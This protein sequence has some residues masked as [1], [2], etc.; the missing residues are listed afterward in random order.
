MVGTL[1][2]MSPEQ[3]E[4]SALGVDTRS[5]IYSLG[6]LLYE[7]LTGT[8][9]L[10]RKRV[11]EAAYAEILRMIREEEPPKPSTRLSDS[12]EALPS[13]SDQPR[14]SEPAKLIEADAR[15]AGLDR[16]EDAGEGPQPPLRIRCQRLAAD[17]QRYLSDEPVQA[18]PPSAMYRFR[19]F[20]RRNKAALVMAILVGSALLL[21]LGALA[22]STF[23]I[24]K[25]QHAT[26]KALQAETQAKADLE[27]TLA[28]ERLDS[29]FHRITL[30]HRE[31]SVDNLGRALQ[32]LSECPEDLRDWEWY[33]LMRLCRVEP[34]VLRDK[35]EVNGIAFSPDGERLASAGGNGLVKIWNSRTGQVIQTFPARTTALLCSVA[36]HPDGKHLASVGSDKQVKVWDLTTE[37]PVFTERCD[38]V[39]VYGISVF[40]GIQSRRKARRRG[41]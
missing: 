6:V 15:R 20:A 12:G 36:F 39:H 1:E 21:T 5:D 8:T 25:E 31:L 11:R 32:L 7:L 19:K 35:T 18:C 27:E 16:D 17:V 2:Y 37:L 34:V 29:Y 9:P 30:V 28:R 24:T 22:V 41:K 23:L 26:A 14:R 13:I 10:S 3:A 38:A 40:R 33:Y 4:M